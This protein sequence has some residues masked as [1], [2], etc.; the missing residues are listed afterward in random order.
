M[1][2]PG[3]AAG[4]REQRLPAPDNT[5]G[6][7]AMIAATACFCC[8]D[9]L[10]KLAS[11]ALPTG[12]CIFIRG[13][14]GAALL[15]VAV[16]ATGKAHTIRSALTKPMG[17]R[18]LGDVG[19]ATFYQSA[20]ARVPFAD[21]AAV[22]QI[23]PLMVTAA[24]ALFLAERVG[25]RRWTAT[26]VGLAGVLLIIR[27]G[28]NA[29]SWWSVL[30]LVS[31][32]FATLRDLAT[33]GVAPETPGLLIAALSTTAVLAMS[34]V[35][36]LFET[37]TLPSGPR[38][39]QLMIAGVFSLA[40]QLFLVASIRAGDVS[41]VVPFRYAAILWAIGLGI[42]VWGEFPDPL[43]LLGIAIVAAAGLYSFFREQKLRRQ[44]RVARASPR[45]EDA[46][47]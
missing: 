27:P 45:T 1:P 31:V 18:A 8:G 26:A 9:A 14:T 46:A 40:G 32:A 21:A 19:G 2:A 11:V 29:F 38:L 24:A 41:A 7:L 25:W 33:R 5:R 47:K 34:A 12:E 37:W 42:V 23:N 15:W 4:L 20:L 43:T 16:F 13:L 35:I 6:I 39:A 36:G 30:L 28:S 44:A 10:M 22:L 17:L 3:D